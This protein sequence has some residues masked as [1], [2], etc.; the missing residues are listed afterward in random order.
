[1]SKENEENESEINEIEY[2]SASKEISEDDNFLDNKNYNIFNENN[3]EEDNDNDNDDDNNNNIMQIDEE[4]LN[5]EIIEGLR[6]L[7]LKSLYNFTKAA[8]NDII[9]LFA[10]KNINLYKVKKILEEFTEL[11]PTFYNICEN[12]C[13]CYIDVYESYQNCPLCNSSRYNSNNKPKKVM[14]YLS[15]KKML[16]IQYNNKVRAKELLYRYEYI[17]NKELDDNDLDDIFDRNIY[18]ELLKRNLFKNNRDIAFTISYD[19]YQIFKQKTDDCWAFL[20]I[21]NNLNPLIRVKKENL[22]IPFLIPGPK[23][24]KDFNT[25]LQPFIKEL[26]GKY[27]I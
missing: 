15:I 20:I 23:Q 27:F 24:P 18:K 9:K 22:L 2:L 10:N 4:R 26:E 14:P 25:F 16:K 8:Y 19:G 11:V 6:L 7:H 17:T 3:S 13:I 21:N 12:S 5:K 1:M